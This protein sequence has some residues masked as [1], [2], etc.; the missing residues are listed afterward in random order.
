M[1]RLTA[2]LAGFAGFAA[3]YRL[4]KRQPQP[5]PAADPADELKAKL[6]TARASEE[7]EAPADVEARRRSVHDQARAA[8]DDM[9][10]DA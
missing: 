6:A 2:W 9:N 4:F 10:A 8:I 5:A 3:L 1:K 7:P